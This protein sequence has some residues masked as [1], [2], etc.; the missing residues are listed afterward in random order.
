MGGG[1]EGHGH[2]S[3]E[4]QKERKGIL[5]GWIGSGGKK[6]WSVYRRVLSVAGWIGGAPFVSTRAR[7]VGLRATRRARDF[8]GALNSSSSGMLEQDSTENGFCPK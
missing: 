7:V 5:K 8:G 1:R 3:L 2:E 4:I 6:S